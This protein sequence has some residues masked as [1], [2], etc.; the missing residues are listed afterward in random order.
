MNICALNY[1]RQILWWQKIQTADFGSHWNTC[2]FTHSVLSTRFRQLSCFFLSWPETAWQRTKKKKKCNNKTFLLQANFANLKLPASS[3]ALKDLFSSFP[4]LS[5]ALLTYFLPR[6]ILILYPQCLSELLHPC[7]F[8][9]GLELQYLCQT[10][11]S[12]FPLLLSH[13]SLMILSFCCRFTELFRFF[14]VCFLFSQ[15]S[16]FAF[17]FVFPFCLMLFPWCI[18]LSS[19]DLSIFCN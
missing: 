16:A 8:S 13:S 6:T 7:P 5:N 9:Y 12:L 10:R 4:F 15:H 14:C 2:Q 3:L 17:L 19:F 1:L 18:F 11:Q